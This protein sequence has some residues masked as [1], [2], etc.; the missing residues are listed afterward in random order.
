VL[1]PNQQEMPDQS[2][3][4]E[5]NCDTLLKRDYSTTWF[6]MSPTEGGAFRLL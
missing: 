4:F 1:N 2:S 5:P 3:E 6:S